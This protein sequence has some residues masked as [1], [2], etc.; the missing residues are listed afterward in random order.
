MF[1]MISD[2]TVHTITSEVSLWVFGIPWAFAVPLV[3][4]GTTK[5]ADDLLVNARHS[6]RFCYSFLGLG[7]KDR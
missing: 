6:C 3:S 7:P 2:Q 4:H 1:W 5:Y